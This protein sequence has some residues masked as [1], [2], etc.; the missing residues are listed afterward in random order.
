[1]SL[2]S[3]LMYNIKIAILN[4]KVYEGGIDEWV[5]NSL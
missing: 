2:S 3:L 1:M 4:L 5:E